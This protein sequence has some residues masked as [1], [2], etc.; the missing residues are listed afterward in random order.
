MARQ[1][2]IALYRG[3]QYEPFSRNPEEFAFW[4]HLCYWAAFREETI[5]INGQPVTL[6]Q[7]ELMYT[8][9]EMVRYTGFSEKRIRKL[10]HKFEHDYGKITRI[11]E[12]HGAKKRAR[13][14]ILNYES[15]AGFSGVEPSKRAK[16]RANVLL[17]NNYKKTTTTSASDQDQVSSPGPT[18][19]DGVFF[20][21]LLKPDENPP[22]KP[23]QEQGNPPA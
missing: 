20:D 8:R 6:E 13:V 19:G 11:I 17:T 1:S 4:V 23:D 5:E 18:T 9:A 12:S 22:T 3:I 10:L 2:F 16:K 14:K 7:G 21:N 15:I